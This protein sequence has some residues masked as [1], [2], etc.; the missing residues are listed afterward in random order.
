MEAKASGEEQARHVYEELLDQIAQRAA[1]N[2]L[3]TERVE[4]EAGSLG[5]ALSFGEDSDQRRVSVFRVERAEELLAV[6]F[7]SYRFVPGYE[8]IYAKD[9]DE[10]EARLRPS[11]LFARGLV[12]ERRPF[13][14]PYKMVAPAA[15]GGHE[16]EIATASD[17]YRALNPSRM[18][19]G[20]SAKTPVLKLRGFGARNATRAR[21]LLDDLVPSVLFELDIVYDSPVE[22]VKARDP[23]KGSARDWTRSDAPPEFPSNRYDNEPLALYTYGRS[24]RGMPLLEYLAYYQSIE[25]YF[26]R[27]SAE[28]VRR[29]VERIVKDPR[30]NPHL[31]RDVG[32]LVEVVQGKGGRTYGSELEQLKATLRSCVEQEEIREFL[33][34]DEQREEFF[35]ERRGPLTPRTLTVADRDTDLRDAT[36]SRI[37]DLRCRIVH[38]K[39]EPEAGGLERLLPNSPEV[40]LLGQDLALLR[41][42][43]VRVIVASSRELVL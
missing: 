39:D 19:A 24:A 28:E 32:R 3:G 10:V 14:Q 7:E 38:T 20:F 12:R 9:G 1:Y 41:L 22:L 43:A 40:Q 29:R 15:S 4:R 31:D 30:F 8:A 26:P 16:I 34:A 18:P 23:R 33:Q 17:A 25:Y 5:L 27:Y 6:P 37:Y 2:E 35:R 21:E 13:D 11:G 36:A 42:L